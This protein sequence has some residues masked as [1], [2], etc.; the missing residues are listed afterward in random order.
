MVIKFG[1]S[2]ISLQEVGSSSENEESLTESSS[3]E[4]EESTEEGTL[5]KCPN[6]EQNTLKIEQGCSSCTNPE[7]GMSKCDS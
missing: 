6:C 1:Q 2:T 5:A 4:A 3:E 7:C